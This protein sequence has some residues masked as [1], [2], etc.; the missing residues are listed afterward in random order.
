[1]ENNQFNKRVVV[2]GLGAVTPVGN[3]VADTWQSLLQGKS[4]IGPITLFDS[5]EL[6]TRFG[7]EVKNFEGEAIFGRKSARRMDRFTQ[8]AVEASRQAIDDA[9]IGNG[10]VDK[11][12]VGTVIG[13]ALGGMITFLREHDALKERGPRRVNPFFIPMILPDTPAAQLSIE[14]GFMGPSMSVTSACATGTNAVG[15]AFEMV[16]RGAADIVVAGGADSLIIP[17]I[18]AGFSVM[19]AFSTR[20]DEPEKACRPFDA[21][22]DGFVAS[23][24]SAILILESLE[25][26]QARGAEIYAEFIGYGTSVDANSMSAPLANGDGASL[27]MKAAIR[28]ANVDPEKVDY[29]NAHGTSTRLNDVAETNAIKQTFGEHAYDLSISSTKSMT[30]HLLGGAGALEALVC[31]KS[32]Q[33]GTIAPTIN[34]E[35]PD[36]DCDLNYTPNDPQQRDMNVAMSNSFG[37]GGHNATVVL[38]KYKAN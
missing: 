36:E 11:T 20:N 17:P 10:A 34:Y 5:S 1:M 22:R 32:L 37:F 28:R 25:H 29:L 26:A 33:T 38:K 3:N 27:A 2:T 19:K 23:E 6:G 9:G 13:S 14:Y 21:T 31:I 30:G 12:R 18:F 4:G 16:A 15:E 8:F 7:G 35:V 24:G